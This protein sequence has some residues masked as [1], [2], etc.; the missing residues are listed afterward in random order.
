MKLL[1]KLP[2]TRGE[3]LLE[4]FTAIL[5]ICCIISVLSTIL[6]SSRVRH[7]LE[8]QKPKILKI[9]KNVGKKWRMMG[10]EED[11]VSASDSQVFFSFLQKQCLNSFKGEAGLER[12]LG[13][14]VDV[15]PVLGIFGQSLYLQLYLGDIQ[16]GALHCT[17][18]RL[19]SHLADIFTNQYSLPLF[20]LSPILI[21]SK[22][23]PDF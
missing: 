4:I 13:I 5:P 12:F 7:K 2:L 16:G 10:L 1:L 22:Y 6:I 18:S 9:V 23:W 21:T 14:C 11:I 20:L 8:L 17:V 15:S 19:S 3:I